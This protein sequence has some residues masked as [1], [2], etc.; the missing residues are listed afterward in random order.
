MAPEIFKT[1][2]MSLNITNIKKDFDLCEIEVCTKCEARRTTTI[3]KNGM[4]AKSI[5]YGVREC[6][7]HKWTYS[8]KYKSEGFKE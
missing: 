2:S 8:F 1:E 5:S 4:R 7:R 6:K 3:K